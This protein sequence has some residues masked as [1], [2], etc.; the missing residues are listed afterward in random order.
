VREFVLRYDLLGLF[1]VLEPS[2]AGLGLGYGQLYYD[3]RLCG[4]FRG[5][6]MS[7]SSQISR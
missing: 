2:I 6:R 4:L 7:L 3:I 5:H 1:A